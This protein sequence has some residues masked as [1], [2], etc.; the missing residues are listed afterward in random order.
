[1]RCVVQRISKKEPSMPQHKPT[2]MT[3][4]DAARIR[5]GEAKQ[6]NGQVPPGGFGARADRV[7]QQRQAKGGAKKP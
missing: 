1:M 7:V 3:P 5:S 6:N 2:P 4:A